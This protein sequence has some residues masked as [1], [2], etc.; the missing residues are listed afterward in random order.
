MQHARPPLKR[1]LFWRSGSY[2]A[3]RKGDWKL[4]VS[5]NPQRKWLFNLAIDPTEHA[6][7]SARRPDVVERL[8]ADL[9]VH[10]RELAKPLW[11][12]LLEEPIRIDVPA[13]APWKSG[14]EYVYWPN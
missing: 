10:D 1:T 11:P 4:Q 9:A 2:E 8:L 12:A 7:L 5:R 14:Q 13:D 6:D 3:V